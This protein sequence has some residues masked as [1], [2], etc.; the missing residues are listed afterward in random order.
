[1]CGIAGFTVARGLSREER[2][3]HGDSLA[4]MTASLRHRGP[5]AQC[6]RVLD[7]AALGHARLAIVDR[8]GGAQPMSD[9]R[10]GVTLV[11]NGEVYNHA[12]LRERWAGDYDFRTRSDTEV[13][14]AGFLR[15]GLA[16]VRWFV[17]Q[18]AFA[19]FDPRDG[20]LSL[21]RDRVGICPLYYARV[22]GGWAFAS[23]IKALF[24]GGHAEA[25]LDPLGVQQSIRLWAPVAPR[26]CFRGVLSLPP[27]HVAR[28]EG[29]GIALSRYWQV[30]APNPGRGSP[31]DEAAAVR[32][33]GER[34]G[35]AVRL[36]LRADV[37]VS[38]YLSGGLDSSALCAVAQRE[39]GGT[40]QTFSVSFDRPE[41]D[42]SGFQREAAAALR[43]DHRVITVGD[44][45]IGA[46]LP[47][48]VW[49]G[50]QVL[51]RSA[52]AP[53]FRL[54]ELVR[55]RGTRVVLTGEGADE[56][57]WGYDLF[58][59]TKLRSFWARQ[60]DSR[61]RPALLSRLYPYMPRM[62]QSPELLAGFFGVGLD[63][64]GS[65]IFSHQ[66]RWAATGRIARFFAP[67]FVRALDGH[68]P[69]Q[70]IAA[71]MPADVTAA[72][73]L[74]RAQYLEAQTLL[75]GYLLSAQGDRMLLGNS[76]EGRFPFLDHRVIEFACALPENFKLKVLVEKYLLR[77]LASDLLPKSLAR[78]TKQPYRAPSVGALVGPSAPRWAQEAFSRE[79]VDEVGVFSGEKVARLAGLAASAG[80]TESESHAMTLMAVASTRLLHDRLVR[81]FQ[82]PKAAVQA[83]KVSV[84]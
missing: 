6:G 2:S 58:K 80:R 20:A 1:M 57:F 53:L 4:R 54:S 9:P 69:T 47:D 33:L 63:Q 21:A 34:L 83:V 28:L 73:P 71:A 8:E 44:A 32:E 18:F 42:E 61:L 55:S 40:L 81:G 52:P 62:R 16:A 15:E 27:A 82:V 36:A 76:V 14:L 41:F 35:S 30:P 48:A 23:E 38:A 64:P 67:S 39:L 59:E 25:A 19:V 12:E 68:D 46:L 75:S 45:D 60:P 56:F 13:V 7:G 51:V 49:H 37:P 65:P 5:D 66:L 17:G 11:F 31:E 22:R 74:A 50:E 84:P 10:T 29:R 3:R 43:T 26:T 78:R 72:R 77:R 70:E 79:G 24:A